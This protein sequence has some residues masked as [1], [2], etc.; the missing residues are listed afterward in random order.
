MEPRRAK[1]E[2]REG[3]EG[4]QAHYTSLLPKGTPAPGQGLE[5]KQ[6]DRS[7]QRNS[8]A[9]AIVLGAGHLARIRLS[10]WRVVQHA[11]RM[12]PGLVGTHF[13]PLA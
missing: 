9:N 10:G 3:K 5:M 7:A 11:D 4:L 2:I 1:L 6:C 12:I 13:P 8:G